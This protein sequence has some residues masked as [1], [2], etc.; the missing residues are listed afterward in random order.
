M[1]NET[2]FDNISRED[3]GP[4]KYGEPSFSYVN[5]TAREY[6]GQARVVLDSWFKEYSR[7]HPDEAKDLHAR[8]RSKDNSSHL[9]ALTE[10]F[11]HDLLLKNGHINIVPHPV[12]NG[13]SARPDFLVIGSDKQNFIVESVIVYGKQVKH[14]VSSFQNDILNMVNKL[15]S[16]EF[17]VSVNFRSC[18]T[19]NPPS[20]KDIKKKLQQY[21]NSLNYGSV[22][23]EFEKTKKMP[24]LEYKAGQWSVKFSISPA[25]E[26][27]QQKRK[28]TQSRNIGIIQY[29]GQ[30]ITLN[31]DIRR[32]VEKKVQKYGDTG[33]PLIIA[34]NIVDNSFFCDDDT[35]L[36]A[37]FGSRTINFQVSEGGVTSTTPGRDGRGII[38]GKSGPRYTRLTGLL[39]F[40]GLT[41]STVERTNPV[42]WHHPAAKHPLN[43]SMFR[44][45]HRIYNQT[46]HKM[47]TVIKE[48]Y[49][50]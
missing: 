38:L 50:L 40:P 17:F 18:D 34:T 26:A 15:D 45:I 24:K 11:T 29:P 32:T 33:L 39:V 21:L 44:V 28:E 16:S 22:C 8:F 41:C 47:D 27:G 14:R 12:L 20:L 46:T 23:A 37:L 1:F 13:T 25:S 7:L 30:S 42:L 35:I 19:E 31:E 5:R 9:A 2:L 43:T 4:A 48:H 6:Y 36:D 49:N 10:L 3:S